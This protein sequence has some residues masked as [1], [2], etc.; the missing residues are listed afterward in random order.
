M[1]VVLI[2]VAGIAVEAVVIMEPGDDEEA[3]FFCVSLFPNNNAD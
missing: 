3:D 1:Y 2:I